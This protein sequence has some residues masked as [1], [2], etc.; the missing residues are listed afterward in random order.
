MTIEFIGDVVS[1][2]KKKGY[3]SISY[4][5][6]STKTCCGTV[7]QNVLSPGMPRPSGETFTMYEKDGIKIY[8][9]EEIRIPGDKLVI[10][11]NRFFM[12]DSISVEEE[13]RGK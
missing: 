12:K 11:R 6:D 5:L 7:S 3:D 9:S 1:F 8:V 13:P 4:H 10:R 2:L